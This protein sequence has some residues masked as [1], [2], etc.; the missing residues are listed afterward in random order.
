MVHWD[1]KML[2]N[3]HKMVVAKLNDKTE[4]LAVIVSGNGAMKF[5]V[6]PR[7]QT[8]SKSINNCCFPDH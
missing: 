5:F 8:E 7:S 4:W 1:D 6:V 3:L 2:P